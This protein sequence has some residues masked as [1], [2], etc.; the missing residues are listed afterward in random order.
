MAKRRKNPDM[1]PIELAKAQGEADLLAV[2]ELFVNAAEK[3]K[4]GD[5]GA[6]GAVCAKMS[7]W[8][9][10][11]LIRHENRMDGLRSDTEKEVLAESA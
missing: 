2:A 10:M 6:M 4:A 11:L 8:A 5:M 3:L 7:G 9:Q 1:T